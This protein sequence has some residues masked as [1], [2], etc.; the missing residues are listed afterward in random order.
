MFSVSTIGYNDALEKFY[1]FNLKTKK[2]TLLHSL[3]YYL[4]IL[5][6]YLIN[7]LALRNNF[8]SF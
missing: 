7:Y 8:F 1:K 6:K 4:N 3:L 5:I 2:R